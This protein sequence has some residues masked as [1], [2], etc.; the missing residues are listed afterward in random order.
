MVGFTNIE[1]FSEWNE[2]LRK[3]I[4]D[5]LLSSHRGETMHDDPRYLLPEGKSLIVIGNRHKGFRD[6]K[7]PAYG[8]I[9]LPL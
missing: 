7:D 4:K 9:S 5:G 1:K 2:I 8:S 3:R 6:E